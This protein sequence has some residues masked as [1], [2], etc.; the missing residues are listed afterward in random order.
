MSAWE[1]VLLVLGGNAALILAAAW[2]ARSLVGQLLAKDLERFKTELVS[3]SNLAAERTKHE[4]QMAAQERSVRFTKLH[5]KRGEVIAEMYG[6]LVEAQWAAQ[7]FTSPAEWAGEPSKNEKYGTALKKSA[8]FFRY[9]D[10]NRIYLP[11]ELCEQ[12][13]TFLNGMRTKVIGFGVYLSQGEAYL[14]DEG[15]RKK[16]EAWSEASRYFDEEVPK[17]RLALE[18]ELRQLIG[19]E[20]RANDG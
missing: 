19:V 10:R 7:D 12:F 6:L 15:I 4:L 13:D 20:A 8:D 9:F 1:T 16:H 2:F 14:P 11:P 5:E 18:T 3:A 17:G